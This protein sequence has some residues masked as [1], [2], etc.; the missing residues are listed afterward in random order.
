MN[1]LTTVYTLGDDPCCKCKY[2][3]AQYFGVSNALLPIPKAFTHNSLAHYTLLALNDAFSLCVAAEE[4]APANSDP[5]VPHYSQQPPHR[6]THAY[7][8]AGI[9]SWSVVCRQLIN[10]HLPTDS[11]PYSHDHN[12]VPTV[13]IHKTYQ[14]TRTTTLAMTSEACTVF[15]FSKTAIVGSNSTRFTDVNRRFCACTVLCRLRPWKETKPRP[16][17]RIKFLLWKREAVLVYSATPIDGSLHRQIKV[18][19][20]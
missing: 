14:K 8:P 19:F 9:T 6:A 20:G 3:H 12:A 5:V 11:A 18:A 15:C 10:S 2:A 1:I 17:N 13:F 16:R 4:F 7:H